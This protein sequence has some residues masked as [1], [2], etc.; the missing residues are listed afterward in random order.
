[1]EFFHAKIYHSGCGRVITNVLDVP[2]PDTGDMQGR[3]GGVLLRAFF[4]ETDIDAL[5]EYLAKTYEREIKNEAD[6]QLYMCREFYIGTPVDC[7]FN[8]ERFTQI[9]TQ[10][11]IKPHMDFYR[12]DFISQYSF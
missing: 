3:E 10:L 5:K 1:M 9:C 8:W 12:C 2:N 7:W 11:E 6:F 4:Y